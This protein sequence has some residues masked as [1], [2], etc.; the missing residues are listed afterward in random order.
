MEGSVKCP[1]IS[2]LLSE[3]GIIGLTGVVGGTLGVGAGKSDVLPRRSLDVIK[4]SPAPLS[5]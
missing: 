4:G 3:V 2:P 5:P 1:N